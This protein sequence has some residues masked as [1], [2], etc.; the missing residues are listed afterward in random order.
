MLI[1]SLMADSTS[2]S[3]FGLP[4]TT[5]A[6]VTRLHRLRVEYASRRLVRLNRKG[7]EELVS[8][9]GDGEDEEAEGEDELKEDGDGEQRLGSVEI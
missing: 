3:P 6:P 5:P 7:I 4:T 8:E 2:S 9:V 1:P